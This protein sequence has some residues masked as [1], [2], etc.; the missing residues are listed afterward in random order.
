MESGD[1]SSEDLQ[2]ILDARA[3]YYDSVVK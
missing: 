3:A 2:E 1:L